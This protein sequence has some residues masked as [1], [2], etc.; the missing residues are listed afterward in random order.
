MVSTAGAAEHPEGI[1]GSGNLPDGGN[2]ALRGRG[3]TG[4]RRAASVATGA[5]I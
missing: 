3:L 5:G 1:G 4:A 2:P